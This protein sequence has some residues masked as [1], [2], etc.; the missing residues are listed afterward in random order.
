M[1][2]TRRTG[3]VF[4]HDAVEQAQAMLTILGREAAL[5]TRLRAM[6]NRTLETHEVRGTL[7]GGDFSATVTFDGR[8]CECRH[9]E[10]CPT[11]ERRHG[12]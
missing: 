4:D 3:S 12:G 6:S 11:K 8:V 7:L 10:S 5:D 2:E 9:D 1:S